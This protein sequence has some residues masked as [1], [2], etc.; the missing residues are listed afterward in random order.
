MTVEVPAVGGEFKYSF[1][2]FVFLKLP[3]HQSKQSHCGQ[4]FGTNA[5]RPIS[6]NKIEAKNDGDSGAYTASRV[7]S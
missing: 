6:S 7:G 1:S 3:A 5:I 2:T 4:C